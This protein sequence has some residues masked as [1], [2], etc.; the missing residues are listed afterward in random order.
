MKKCTKCGEE[1]GLGEFYKDKQ[2][3]LELSPYCKKCMRQI[4][5]KDYV[6]HREQRQAS[7]RKWWKNNSEKCKQRAKR[8]YLEQRTVLLSQIRIRNAKLFK[9]CLDH[10]GHICRLCGSTKNLSMDHIGGNN[11]ESPKAGARLWRWI[12]KHSFPPGFRTLCRACNVRDAKLR[13]KKREE[14]KNLCQNSSI[15]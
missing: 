5:Q 10:Y 14:A 7:R 1:K 11:G 15:T 9:Q 3:K 12:I 8:Y 6:T 2:R 4:M 13:C